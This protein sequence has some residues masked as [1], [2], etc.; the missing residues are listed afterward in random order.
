MDTLLDLYSDYLISLF[1][2]TTATGLALTEPG[3]KMMQA[4]PFIKLF[5][6][7]R[8]ELRA[9][10]KFA[11]ADKVR[12]DLAKPGAVLDRFGAAR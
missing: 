1:G 6:A 8:K 5:I 12:D 10:K 9:A 4:I 7:P 11:F 3:S 2:L